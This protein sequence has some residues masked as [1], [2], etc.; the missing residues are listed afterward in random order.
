MKSERVTLIYDGS[1]GFCRRWVVRVQH[2]DRDGCF[3]VVPYQIPD[4]EE[5]FPN[6]SRLDCTHRMHLVTAD[7]T[8][9]QGAAAGR[10]LLRRLRGG[11]LWILP[12]HIPGGLAV[13]EHLYAW[14]A[15]RW[16][17]TGGPHS[18]ERSRGSAKKAVPL[19]EKGEP[20]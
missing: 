6:V 13:T 18:G 14:I 19:P 3:E 12:F 2:W 7:G 16:G 9:Y 8:V 1:C 10:E 20:S 17:P 11:W 5:R 4:L 15:R